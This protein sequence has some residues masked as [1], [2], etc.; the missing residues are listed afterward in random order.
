[1]NTLE[2]LSVPVAQTNYAKTIHKIKKLISN[3]EKSFI[4]VSAVHLIMECQ[5]N[6]RLLEGVK[7]AIMVVPDGMP[8]VWLSKLYGFKKT[9]RVYGP[10]LTLILCRLAEKYGYNVLFLG[11]AKGQSKIVAQ[12]LKK[13]FPGLRVVGNI[14][15]PNLPL[16]EKENLK[17]IKKINSNKADVIFVGMGCPNQEL[18]MIEN[19]NKVLAPMLIGVGAAFDFI[20]GRKKQAPKWMQDIGL[21]WFYRLIQEPRRL[22]KRYFVLNTLFIIKVSKNII[23]DLIHGKI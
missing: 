21:E 12:N 2:I 16:N 13:M 19:R 7:K 14:D 6:H 1:M 22:F 4:C 11:G 23:S 17:I 18:W 20:S 15:T 8:L 10:N 5:S 3:K 9:S